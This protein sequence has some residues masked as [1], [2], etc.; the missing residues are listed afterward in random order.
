MFRSISQ[1]IA[2][3]ARLA[4]VIQRSDVLG[5]HMTANEAARTSTAVSD[6]SGLDWAR[7]LLRVLEERGGI[8]EMAQPEMF[9]VRVADE[10]RRTGFAPSYEYAAGVGASTVDFFV[11]G[12]PSFLLEVLS[13]RVSEGA[14]AANRSNGPFT[15]FSLSSSN[16]DDPL[17]ARESIE[18]E[19]LVAQ[20]KL[21]DKVWQSGKPTKFPEPVP[22]TYHVLVADVRGLFGGGENMASL[23]PDLKVLTQGFERV[24]YVEGHPIKIGMG[25][26]G[27]DGTRAVMGIFEAHP[28]HPLR[29]AQRLRSAVHAVHFVCETAYEPRE[30]LSGAASFVV[31]NRNLLQREEDFRGFSSCYPLIRPQQSGDH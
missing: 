16:L 21:G 24:D 31:V 26:P 9:E 1:C 18:S 6:L 15:H 5:D 28:D 13:L 12:Q 4:A 27:P 30:M 19:V 8:S 2:I 29:S 7:P 23:R 20:G 17:R 25:V 14:R 11:P 22:G 10:L 3:G